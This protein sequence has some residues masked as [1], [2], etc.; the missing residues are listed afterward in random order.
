MGFWTCCTCLAAIFMVAMAAEEEVSGVIVMYDH[1]ANLSCKDNSFDPNATQMTGYLLM[2]LLPNGDLV[3]TTDD[4]DRVTVFDEGRQITVKKVD[5]VDFGIYNCIIYSS[6]YGYQIVQTGINL[7]GPYWGD[8]TAKYRMNFIV[9]AVAAAVVFLIMMGFCYWIGR[10]STL[11]TDEGER[12]KASTLWKSDLGVDNAA[13][14]LGDVQVDTKT[15]PEN[16]NLPIYTE[17][18]NDLATKL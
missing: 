18:R 6:Q 12:V 17:I 14:E 2:W 3:K 15:A 5:D 7:N 1:P 16:G 10:N 11:D 8:L 13:V 9:G 4:H